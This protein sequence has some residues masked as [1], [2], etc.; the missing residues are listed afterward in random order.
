MNPF[1]RSQQSLR[2]TPSARR[3]RRR[4]N[5]LRPLGPEPL[6]ARAVPVFFTPQ[7]GVET[8]TDN[9]GTVLPNPPVY[10]IFW[11]SGWNTS[12]SPSTS[13]VVNAASSILSG[14]Y[15]SGLSQYRPGAGLGHA[16]FSAR[17][18]IID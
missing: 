16:D 8:A 9:G 3:A 7:A 13:S 6:E 15:L 14:P 1:R 11:G 17:K 5:A 4:N 2:S 12:T 18:F 10:L